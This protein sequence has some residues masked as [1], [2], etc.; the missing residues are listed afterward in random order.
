MTDSDFSRALKHPAVPRVTC[1]SYAGY[2]AHRKHDEIVC[3]DCKA[4]RNQWEKG[5][6][7]A[8]ATAAN[9]ARLTD[10][11]R[12]ALLRSIYVP[13][14]HKERVIEYVETLVA[15]RLIRYT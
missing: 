11:E 12:A 14:E 7:A 5:R 8:R 15:D 4:A 10:V 9:R 2:K 3:D 13:L 6:R 1:G